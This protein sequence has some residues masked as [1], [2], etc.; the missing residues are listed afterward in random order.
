MLGHFRGVEI[1]A[2]EPTV[3]APELN[4]AV[5]TQVAPDPDTLQAMRANPVRYEDP[6]VSVNV[7]I[8]DVLAKKQGDSRRRPRAKSGGRVLE[9]DTTENK[10]VEVEKP[11]KIYTT[12]AHV[13][14]PIGERILAGATVFG[15]SMNASV[16][17]MHRPFADKPPRFARRPT[18]QVERLRRAGSGQM[19]SGAVLSQLARSAAHG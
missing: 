15:T 7:S 13:Q 2:S 16:R 4:E 3:L 18:V 12:V 10:S 14:T 5:L 19:G 11:K 17:P 6:K 1:Q 8:D 9:P